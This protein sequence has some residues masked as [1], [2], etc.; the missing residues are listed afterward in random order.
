[1]FRTQS[2]F[3][4]VSGLFADPNPELTNEPGSKHAA[5]YD[6]Y[7]KA[8]GH[9][10]APEEIEYCLRIAWCLEVLLRDGYHLTRAP[11]RGLPDP[12]EA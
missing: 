4:E 12:A 1:M 5:F 11:P 8:E 7:C 6:W 9:T 2:G 3:D 10:H